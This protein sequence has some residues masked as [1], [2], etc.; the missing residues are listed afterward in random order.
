MTVVATLV[1][2][3]VGY[4]LHCVFV[5]NGLFMYKER[6]WLMTKF[7]M[8]LHLLVTCVDAIAQLLSILNGVEDL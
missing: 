4:C 2:Q 1:H 3:A 8:E 5:D 7:E 6:E